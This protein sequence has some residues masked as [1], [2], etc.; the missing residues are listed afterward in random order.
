MG[1]IWERGER[2][3]VVKP[4]EVWLFCD[5]VH[6]AE[7]QIDSVWFPRPQTSGQLSAD[8]ACHG[9]RSEI[10]IIS[11]RVELDVG[12]YVFC[13]LYYPL[14]ISRPCRERERILLLPV[15]P[16]SPEKAINECLLSCFVLSSEALRIVAPLIA[17]F[18]AATMV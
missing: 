18:D 13:K 4:V 10:G 17:A 6:T 5:G 14:R 2:R 7:K 8:K 9:R 12:L 15:S 3:Q 16:A 1:C 11:H